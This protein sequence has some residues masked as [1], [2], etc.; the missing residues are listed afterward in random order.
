MREAE[1]KEIILTKIPFLT[2]YLFELNASPGQQY[3]NLTASLLALAAGVLSKTRIASS[4]TLISASVT[5]SARRRSH[6]L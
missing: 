4:S 5:Q 2:S 1:A 3:P 6:R